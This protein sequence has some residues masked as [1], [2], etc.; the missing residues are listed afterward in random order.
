MKCDGCLVLLALGEFWGGSEGAGVA[1]ES[2]SLVGEGLAD[3]M[4]AHCVMRP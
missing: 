3:L 4:R 2:L 1:G